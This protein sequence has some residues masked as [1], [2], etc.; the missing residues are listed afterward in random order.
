MCLA[1]TLFIISK[2]VARRQILRAAGPSEQPRTR[3]IVMFA[4]LAV[5]SLL[6]TWSFM[7]RYFEWSYDNWLTLR[8]QGDLDPSVK[9]WGIWLKDTSLFKEAWESVI[10]GH[11]RFWWSHQIF[12]FAT[13]LGL[14]SEW[15]GPLCILLSS[16]KA[17]EYRPTSRNCPH[18]G[19]HAPRADC[20]YQLCY[21]PIFLD[22]ASQSTTRA[23]R[24]GTYQIFFI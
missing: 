5:C 8:A 14:H 16:T 10:V 9:H 6:S 7:F 18:L 24:H 15:K 23:A 22:I 4:V 2:L 1:V 20:S 3:H 12:F 19:V 21:K 13:A 11:D 17:N